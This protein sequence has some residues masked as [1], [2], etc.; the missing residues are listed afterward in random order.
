M[1]N[2]ALKIII[3]K[4]NLIEIDGNV[5]HCT[6]VFE[7]HGLILWMN[8]QK[9]STRNRKFYIK[10]LNKIASGEVKLEWLGSRPK[11][12]LKSDKK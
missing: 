11:L 1:L 5:T 4:N 2:K 3:K 9:L 7:V 6:N 10:Q 12:T 8:K